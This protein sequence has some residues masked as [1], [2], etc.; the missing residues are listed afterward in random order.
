MDKSKQKEIE[1]YN[2]QFEGFED[3]VKPVIKW[4]AEN[5]HP[6]SMVVIDSLHAELLE[7]SKSVVTDEYLV[8]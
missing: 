5:M 4:M 7:G 1:E 6:H 3:V 2:A 8:D